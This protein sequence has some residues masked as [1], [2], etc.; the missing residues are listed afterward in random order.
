MVKNRTSLILM[1][2]SK[3]FQFFIYKRIKNRHR[4]SL[5]VPYH[6]LVT[7]RPVIYIAMVAIVSFCTFSEQNH[8]IFTIV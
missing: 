3:L 7:W 4:P 5:V 2:Q 8:K 6:S 1:F